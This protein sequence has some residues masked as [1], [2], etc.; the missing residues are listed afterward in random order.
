[1]N[2]LGGN[3]MYPW[4]KFFKNLSFMLAAG[5]GFMAGM[6]GRAGTPAV[7]AEQGTLARWSAEGCEACG[8]L[9]KVWKPVDDVCWYPIDLERRPGRYD[10][11]RW[12]NGTT[13]TAASTTPPRR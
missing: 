13:P 4:R 6:S 10:I 11:A 7:E 1:M 8:M 5:A 9:G 12:R 3:H 2:A